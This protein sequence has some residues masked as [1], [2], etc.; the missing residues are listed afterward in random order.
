VNVNFTT[1]R[2]TW[3]LRDGNDPTGGAWRKV[4]DLPARYRDAP[5]LEA[6]NLALL[7]ERIM[8]AWRPRDDVD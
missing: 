4:D 2:K 3:F 7:Q 6:V 8:R 5:K 1:G